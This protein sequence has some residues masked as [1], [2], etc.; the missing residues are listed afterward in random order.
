MK[1]FNYDRPKLKA[2]SIPTIFPRL[3][4][5]FTKPSAVKRKN[6]EERNTEIAERINQA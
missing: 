5:Y 3:P 1:T 2:D 6:P 4:K